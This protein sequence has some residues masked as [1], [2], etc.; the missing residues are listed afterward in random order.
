[1][2][3]PR[4]AIGFVL[5][6]FSSVVIGELYA[7]AWTPADV[8]EYLGE[9][10]PLSGPYRPDHDL[11]ADY[12]SFDALQNAYVARF[13]ELGPLVSPR[14]TWLWFGNSFVQA[15]GMLGDIAVASLPD[16]RMFYL[17]RNEPLHLRVAQARTLLQAGLRPDRMFFVMLPIDVVGYA[18]HPL[19]SIT[20]T[21]RGA[22]TY[23]IGEPPFPLHWLS[24]HSMLA[25]IAWVRK[26][27][28]GR[29]IRAPD[30]TTSVPPQLASQLATILGALADSA[31]NF[32][33]PLT[34]VLLPNREQ[35]LGK[36]GFALQE[37][38]G[39]IAASKGIDVFDARQ[40][41]A[42]WSNKSHLFLRD[43]HFTFVANRE[44]FDALL[45]HLN[46]KG[47]RIPASFGVPP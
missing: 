35:I 44:I 5:G 6:L 39:E 23:D 29:I 20:V 38:L 30:V 18:S 32:D 16:I 12:A 7:R 28:L 17:K 21:R 25:R 10:S 15:N 41:F 14:P 31:T 11:G 3:S 40:V 4:V 22:I 26:G 24:S 27:G 46:Q 19:A 37:F 1:M 42:N 9:N 33:V 47:I 2:P 8:L 13:R 34:L 45:F 36:A 43:W